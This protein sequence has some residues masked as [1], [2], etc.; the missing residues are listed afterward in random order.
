M[1]FLVVFLCT[2]AEGLIGRLLGRKPSELVS[3]HEY[4]AAFS[5]VV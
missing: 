1:V 5:W 4:N 3:V 2:F